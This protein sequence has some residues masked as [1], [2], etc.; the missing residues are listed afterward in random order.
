MLSNHHPV[1]IPISKKMTCTLPSQHIS[2]LATCVL[3]VSVGVWYDLYEHMLSNHHPVAIPISK[4]M[5]CTFRSMTENQQCSG[6][7]PLVI[8]TK[9]PISHRV[10]LATEPICFH[11]ISYTCVVCVYGMCKSSSWKWVWRQGDDYSAYVHTNHTTHT[12]THNTCVANVL[13]GYRFSD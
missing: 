3:C 12:D 8:I 2:T 10:F 4:K 9:I 13:E 6:S 1:A 11:H 7:H 5:T